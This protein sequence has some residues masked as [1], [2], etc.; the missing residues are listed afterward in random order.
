MM[1]DELNVAMGL[2][3]LAGVAVGAV[4]QLRCVQ[5]ERRLRRVKAEHEALRA[6]GDPIV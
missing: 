3:L 5:S 1:V 2:M 4:L 6:L